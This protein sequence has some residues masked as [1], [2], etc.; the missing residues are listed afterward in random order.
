MSLAGPV[1]KELYNTGCSIC[2][3]NDQIKTSKNVALAIY[4][5]G[6]IPSNVFPICAMCQKIRHG[7]SKSQLV[8]LAA[9]T[10]MNCR[11]TPKCL[12]N[13]YKKYL[14]MSSLL[15]HAPGTNMQTSTRAH[16]TNYNTYR[17]SAKKRCSVANGQRCP[18][19]VFTLT[20]NQFDAIRQRDCFFCGL[21][22]SNGIDRLYPS[23]GYTTTNSVPCCKT[24]NYA[25][26]DMHPATYVTHLAN[27][28]R[29]N[30]QVI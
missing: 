7:L 9:Q 22:D 6:Y 20:R 21:H 28:V 2:N 8:A 29:T 27:I 3:K 10:I 23:M 5:R 18:S 17:C 11:L 26:N 15:T 30:A 16:S 14:R 12:G 4:S 1:F 25:K 19:S 24:C 13:K